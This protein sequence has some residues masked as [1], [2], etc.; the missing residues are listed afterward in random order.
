MGIKLI[1]DFIDVRPLEQRL[2]GS[3]HGWPVFIVLEVTLW[4]SVVGSSPLPILL[5]THLKFH[6]FEDTSWAQISF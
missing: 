5:H 6:L 3:K 2:I 4:S 1:N